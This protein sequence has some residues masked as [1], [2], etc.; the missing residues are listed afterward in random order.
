MTERKEKLVASKINCPSALFYRREIEIDICYVTLSFVNVC[1]NDNK[2]VNNPMHLRTT[3]CGVYYGLL[4]II[5]LFKYFLIQYRNTTYS[6]TTGRI[7]NESSTF[8]VVI[9]T[10]FSSQESYDWLCLNS[11]TTMQR[12]RIKAATFQ[13]KEKYRW[14]INQHKNWTLSRNL[15]YQ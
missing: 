4:T 9:P 2:T 10:S 15:Q 12:A 7:K 11:R 5:F 8:F 3:V 1:I 14:R 6:E 13:R